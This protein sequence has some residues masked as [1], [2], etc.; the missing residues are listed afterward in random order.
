MAEPICEFR[1]GV[2][3]LKLGADSEWSHGASFEV[4]FDE[5]HERYRV[6][7]DACK[8]NAEGEPYL[9]LIDGEIIET[10]KYRLAYEKARDNLCTA[11]GSIRLKDFI[12]LIPRDGGGI[13]SPIVSNTSISPSGKSCEEEMKKKWACSSKLFPCKIY[14]GKGDEE[15]PSKMLMYIHIYRYALLLLFF[16]FSVIVYLVF[17]ANKKNQADA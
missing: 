2:K 8:T 15:L 17:R 12:D 4:G 16:V 1:L 6:C 14:F 13:S 7:S 9:C 10:S 11:F 5:D 3:D